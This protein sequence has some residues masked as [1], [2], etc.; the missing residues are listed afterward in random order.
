MV[1]VEVVNLSTRGIRFPHAR[2]GM[3][4]AQPYLPRDSF[5]GEEPYQYVP[6]AKKQQLTILG[7]TLAVARLSHHGGL[8]THFTIIPEYG[9][10]GLDGVRVLED[11]LRSKD[12]P[13]GSVV[14]GGTD[15]LTRDQYAELLQGHRTH[16]EANHNGLDRVGADEW[17]NCEITWVKSADGALE[18]WIQPKL[19]PAW[20][21]QDTL[22]QHMFQGRSIY[23]FK[24]QLDNDAHFLFGTLVCFDWV[25]HISDRRP[26]QW[27]LADIHK[28]AGD[29][30][31]PLTWL[32]IIQRNPKPSHH[33]FLSNIELFFNQV[34]SPNADRHNACLVFANTAGKGVPGRADEFGA[35][36]IVLSPQ[37]LFSERTCPP[38]F[39]NGGRQFRDGSDVV[40]ASAC[41]DVFFR[42]RGACIHSFAQINP[43]SVVAGPAGRTAA[44]ENAA[45]F[46]I[47]GVPEPRAPCAPVPA[48]IKW[49][50]DALDKVS[51]LPHQYN[52]ALAAVIDNSHARTVEALRFLSSKNVTHAVKLS[53]KE[54]K[55]DNQIDDWG[56]KEFDGVQHVV[57]TLDIVG[58]APVLQTIGVEPIHAVTVLDER[59]VDVVAIRGTSHEECVEHLKSVLLKYRRGQLL[60]VSRDTDNTSWHRKFRSI[61]EPVVPRP[62]DERKFTDP[63]GA[64]LHIGYQNLL[65]IFQHATDVAGIAE[66][67]NAELTA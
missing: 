19:H 6:E 25:A 56:D 39:S 9:I 27:I 47:S 65:S 12:W 4:V 29:G 37:A 41:K 64:S 10:P 30:Q 3:V 58:V 57:H 48:A 22:H 1:H 8:K 49:L 31:L 46:P 43:G 36:S 61:L 40:R 26:I 14:V 33:T 23:M 55:P 51:N 45:V 24:G 13:N 60:L 11:G 21:E 62:A 20:E 15:G 16:V 38:T 59:Q 35:C 17:V 67:I 54:S 44:V 5:T 7:E 34:E 50:N 42:E 2:V 18:R 63:A 53:A 52:L 32:F 28:R 66:G